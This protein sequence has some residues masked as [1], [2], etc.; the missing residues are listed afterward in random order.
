MTR[1]EH[2]YTIG[3]EECAEIAQRLSKANRFGG[4]EVQPGQELTNRQRILQETADLLG[5]LE[6]LG[7][8]I[9]P[10][11]HPL[12]PW[13]EAKKMK[14]EQYMRYSAECGTL[15]DPHA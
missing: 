2:L 9:V 7:F 11:H 15:G 13:M 14:V 5:V 1:D 6:M 4:D 8:S 3:A 10:Q 12:R